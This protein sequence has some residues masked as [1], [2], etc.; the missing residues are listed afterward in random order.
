MGP[1]TGR[2]SRQEDV[3]MKRR[4]P[5]SLSPGGLATKVCALLLVKRLV[6][7]MVILKKK[8]F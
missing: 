2:E 1:S 7:T 8:A 4:L 3:R 5:D 6:L